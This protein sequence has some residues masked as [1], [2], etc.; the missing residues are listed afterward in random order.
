M[1][2]VVKEGLYHALV[3]WPWMDEDGADR[4]GF[5]LKERGGTPLVPGVDRLF[6]FVTADARD[7]AIERARALFGPGCVRAAGIVAEVAAVPG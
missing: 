1:D 2:G 7:D 4:V 3:L 5:T 6:G